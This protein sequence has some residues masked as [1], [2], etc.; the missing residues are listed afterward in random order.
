MAGTIDT[1]DLVLVED[2]D[3]TA[4]GGTSYSGFQREGTGCE[5]GQISAGTIQFTRT[6]TSADL[7][8]SSLHGWMLLWNNPDTFTVAGFGIVVGDGTNTI[9]YAVGG[10]GT[11]DV[12]GVFFKNGWQSFQLNC[13]SPP[14]DFVVI[15]GS[16]ASLNMA[17]ITTIGYYMDATETALGKVDNCF[18]DI[19]YKYLNAN[20]PAR[21]EG[22]TSGSPATFGDLADND[23][24]SAADKA[25]GIMYE[26]DTGVFEV[27]APIAIGDNGTGASYFKSEN[28]EIIFIDKPVSNFKFDLIG[29]ST[30]QNEA[31]FIGVTLRGTNSS[32]D[33]TLDWSD[34]NFEYI[35]VDACIFL[36]IGTIDLATTSVNRFI[37]NS[38]FDSC[39]II[40]VST[41][42]FKDSTVRNAVV[43]IL[44]SSTSHNISG[45]SFTDNT[46]AIR[47]DTAGTFS[48]ANCP[49]SGNTNDV[50]NAVE[51]TLYDSH[52]VGG[53][54]QKVGDET[55]IAAGQ[56]FTGTGGVLS[57]A[58]LRLRE[59][60]T[61]TGNAVAKVYA[62]TGS[63]PNR[64]PTGSV[65]ATSNLVDV[66][67]IGTSYVD[68]DFEFEDEFSLVNG[69]TYFIVL[70]YT[71]TV[72]NH[73]EW[74]YD[75][76]N[77]DTSNNFAT[78]ISSWTAQT[79]WDGRYSMNVGGI[80]KITAT[81]TSNP[82]SVTNTATVK[83]AT[84]IISAKNLEFT[85][86]IAGSEVRAY[87]GT[88]T[89][90]TNAIEI[91]GV[92]SSGTSFDFD[93]QSGGVAGYIIIHK[94]DYESIT[95]ELT[96]ANADQS[97]PIQQ[98]FD[99][100][101]DNP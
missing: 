17:A 39:G 22:G 47:F 85:G 14:T 45:I 44:L 91:G 34:T 70:E 59:V 40:T 28:E 95:L 5:G 60:G 57:R 36:A 84:I 8:A 55:T 3:G 23:F 52:G 10:T 27:Q 42:E 13:A 11:P 12:Q 51:A 101:Y 18:V 88:T 24:S 77:G 43:G 6:I 50:E 87:T 83:G 20:Y 26:V 96:Y 78:Y 74:E 86:L 32:I 100:N 61:A 48:L 69:T 99:R 79:G 9:A 75:N 92:E 19:M 98:R 31:Y 54:N 93:H 67:G 76:A 38:I 65:L 29:N 21:I 15:A 25:Y 49:F 16:E 80:V 63:D 94:E 41:M 68:V 30:G 73:L 82:S 7:S 56:S 89:D 4:F 90:P 58:T 1:T 72:T 53:S 62:S 37:R 33:P 66:S 81:G 64:V 71:G 35:Q 2:A 97:I 46:V